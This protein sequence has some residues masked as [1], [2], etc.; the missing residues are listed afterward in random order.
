MARE[1]PAAVVFEDELTIA[2]MD[3]GQVTQGHVLVATKRHADNLY[4]LTDA[5]AAAVMQTSRR[6]ALAAQKAFPSAGLTLLQANGAEGG[7]TV[8]HFHMHVVPRHADDGIN[9][10]WP[11]KEPGPAVLGEYAQRLKAALAD[12]AV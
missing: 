11:R 4:E 1:I 8:K 9:L 10:T 2:F 3:L 7:Q 5:E 6:I 12:A